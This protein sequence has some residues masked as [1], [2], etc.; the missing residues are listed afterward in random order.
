MNYLNRSP[1]KNSS[2]GR[3]GWEDVPVGGCGAGSGGS[4]TISAS[5]SPAPDDEPEPPRPDPDLSPRKKPRK[6][7]YV[8]LYSPLLWFKIF[9]KIIINSLIC[10][11]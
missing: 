8:H 3:S 10:Y 1:N 5:S 11:L 4:T 9:L 7:M 6:Q 2:F